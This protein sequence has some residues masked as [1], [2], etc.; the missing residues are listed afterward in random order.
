M[1]SPTKTV[2]L[3]Y[4]GHCKKYRTGAQA[5]APLEWTEDRNQAQLFGS[6]GHAKNSARFYAPTEGIRYVKECRAQATAV[7][8]VV[9]EE[10]VAPHF[11]KRSIIEK[12]VSLSHLPSGELEN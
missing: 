9:L 2:W 5:N 11:I 1:S 4:C 12:G 7:P 8:V 3:G 6:S 10:E